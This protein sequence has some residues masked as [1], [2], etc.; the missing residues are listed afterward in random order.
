M[1]II[2][3]EESNVTTVLLD[4]PDKAHAYHRE[5]LEELQQAISNIATPVAIIASTGTTGPFCGGADLNEMKTAKPEDAR[6]LFSQKV[7]NQLARSPFVSIAAIQGP[8]I[9]GGFELALACD[10]RVAGP[11]ARFGLPEVRLGL[12]PAAGGSTRLPLLVGQARARQIIL[13]GRELNA[14]EALEWGVVS[15]IA[16]NP[17]E[18]AQI[19]SKKIAAY[20]PGA[21]EMAKQLLDP[22]IE[23]QLER[24]RTTQALLYARRNQ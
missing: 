22:Q 8:A 18:A 17:L 21:L 20:D 6:Q 13:G 2:V 23:D 4:R 16:A 3:R 11:Q 1:F 7:F 10:L 19:W 9:A 12:I 24:E 5:L 15:Q 14:E